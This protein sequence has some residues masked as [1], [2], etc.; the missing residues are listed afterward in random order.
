[1]IFIT[2]GAYQGKYKYALENFTD[3]Y[4]IINAY[5]DIVRQ[6]LH[7]GKNPLLEAE[8]LLKYYEGTADAQPE[9]L[10]IICDEV[11]CGV[12]PMDAFERQYRE[13]VGRTACLFA[14]RADR[15]LRLVCGIPVRLK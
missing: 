11:G 15:V 5:Q 12:I 4:T 10:I 13:S 2:G 9:S 8:S 3:E 14:D 1:M 6:Q 7:Q